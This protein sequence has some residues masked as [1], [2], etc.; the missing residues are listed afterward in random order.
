MPR[1][2]RRRRPGADRRP[3]PGAHPAP[4][5]RPGPDR[6]RARRLAHGPGASARELARIPLARGARR[7][8]RP[9]CRPARRRDAMAVA[10]ARGRR[11]AGTRRPGLDRRTGTRE[12]AP[13]ARTR[14]QRR[15]PRALAAHARPTGVPCLGARR[16]T[17][18]CREVCLRR[19]RPREPRRRTRRTA[20]D[21][22]ADPARGISPADAGASE[23][24][25]PA[26][27]AWL[28]RAAFRGGAAD[29]QRVA[30]CGRRSRVRACGTRCVAAHAARRGTGRR[31]R[32]AGSEPRG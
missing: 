12:L 11:L 16:G 3:A 14:R 19:R 17:G 20:G 26:R 32:T 22:S 24:V 15:R 4:P 10:T 18:A 31:A 25:R 9:A 1:A 30:I 5:S 21:R 27:A 13:V 7:A 2:P 23:L 6:R 28:R 8:R 29:R